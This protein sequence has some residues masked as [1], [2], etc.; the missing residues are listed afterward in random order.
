[1]ESLDTFVSV[2][3]SCVCVIPPVFVCDSFEHYFYYDRGL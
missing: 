3:K 1:M 2:N